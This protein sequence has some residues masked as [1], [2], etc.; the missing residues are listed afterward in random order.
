MRWRTQLSHLLVSSLSMAKKDEAK[1]KK[2][3]LGCRLVW[4]PWLDVSWTNNSIEKNQYLNQRKNENKLVINQPYQTVRWIMYTLESM[5]YLHVAPNCDQ[6]ACFTIAFIYY[7]LSLLACYHLSLLGPANCIFLKY[8]QFESSKYNSFV[9][10]K[11]NM[12]TKEN[13]TVLMQLFHYE[14]K[15]SRKSQLLNP[16]ESRKR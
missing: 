7:V 3:S 6:E 12:L 4:F 11:I 14:S 2:C 15:K 13:L 5:L 10:T 16:V 8:I 1:E 9:K